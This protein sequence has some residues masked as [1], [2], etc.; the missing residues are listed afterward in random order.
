VLA[1]ARELYGEPQPYVTMYDDERA[2][3]A[4]GRPPR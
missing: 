2:R 1:S 3:E 4:R